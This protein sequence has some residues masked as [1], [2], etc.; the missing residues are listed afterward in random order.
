ML[1]GPIQFQYLGHIALDLHGPKA[2]MA[3]H[4]E[5]FWC[6]SGLTHCWELVAACSAASQGPV[7]YARIRLIG[8]PPDGADAGDPTAAAEAR[9]ARRPQLRAGRERRR[10]PPADP[11]AQ[12]RSR[13]AR[14]RASGGRRR[15][16]HQVSFRG[17]PSISACGVSATCALRQV[18]T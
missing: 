7:Q 3:R 5:I 1:F 17:C 8:D 16:L 15:L 4:S 12:P 18:P 9:D 14:C 6:R 11:Q 13:R 10:G 2:K